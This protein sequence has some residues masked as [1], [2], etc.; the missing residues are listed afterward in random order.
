MKVALTFSGCHRRG[1]VERIMLECANFMA[2]RGH[3]T[4]IVT[5]EHDAQFLHP[6]IVVHGVNV[7]NGNALSQLKEFVRSGPQ[8]VAKVAPES[9]GTFGAVTPPGVCWVQSVHAA[10]MEIS[11]QR[12]DWKG[13]LKQRLN[14]FH[15]YVLNLEKERFGGRKYQHLIALTP[16]VKADLM[17][18]Y[19]VPETD[20]AVIPN[21]FEPKEF[22]LARC[23][24]RDETRANLGV[25]N[26]EKVV[27]FCANE[28]ERKGFAPLFRALVSLRRDD[29]K[30][31][32]VGRLDSEAYA[33]EIERSGWGNRV[34]FTGPSSDVA[35]FYVASD[36]F[37]LPTQYEAWGLVIVEA[38][39]CGLPVLT[40]ALAGAAVAVQESENPEHRTGILLQNP[41]DSEE[42]AAKIAPLLDGKHAEAAAISRSVARYAWSE[43]LLDYEK[44]LLAHRR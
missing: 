10:W 15:P 14:P 26:G 34:I 29:V 12:R 2:S 21:G 44:L 5:A 36:V 4:H 16:D 19:G 9:L 6:E 24:N 30:L 7:G 31:L 27:V 1:G 42:I 35:Q 38:M 25:E 22:C 11:A 20:I 3:E 17:R 43:V 28:L 41:N 37:A 39:A 18:F 40:S 33:A 8:V 32:A 13:R 23:A